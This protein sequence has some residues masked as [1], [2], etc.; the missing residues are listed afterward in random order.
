MIVKHRWA[1]LYRRHLLLVGIGLA[2][3]AGCR[4]DA[5]P[6]SDPLPTRTLAPFTPS[7]SPD[8]PIVAPT[9]TPTELPDPSSLAQSPTEQ[10][11]SLIPPA[12]Q[13]LLNITLNDLTGEQG[14]SRDNVRLL[15][16]ESFTWRDSSWGCPGHDETVSFTTGYRIIYS[17]GGRIFAYHTDNEETFF[18]CPDWV[19]LQGEPLPADPIAASMVE[20]AARDVA[21]RFSVPQPELISLIAVTWSDSSLG[22]PRVSGDYTNE[23]IDG[24]RIVFRVN[25]AT[26]I[27]HTSIRELFFCLPEDEILP[28]LLNNIAPPE[29]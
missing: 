24:Y 10:R 18:L 6:P 16:L 19:D 15:S 17:A 3:L 28:G 5:A 26:A 22:C 27:Y 12:A 25:E 20:L 23:E 8:L 29:E 2:L 7:P 14:E 9:T 21:S 4:S 1:V 13:H 11:V